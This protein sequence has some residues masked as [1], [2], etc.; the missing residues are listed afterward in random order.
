VAVIASAG[1]PLSP[2]HPDPAA[3]EA[4]NPRSHPDTSAGAGR[5]AARAVC[6]RRPPLDRPLDPRIPQPADRAGA[7]GTSLDAADIPPDVSAAMDRPR[8]RNAPYSHSPPCSQVEAMIARLTHGKPFP[9]EVLRH[10]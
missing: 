10:V 6:R 1:G 7:Y 4:T 3:A 5:T 9:T 2:T 8:A